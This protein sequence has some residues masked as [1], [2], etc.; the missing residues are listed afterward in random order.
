MAQRAACRWYHE[1]GAEAS[2]AVLKSVPE[3]PLALVGQEMV[4]A[5]QALALRTPE[6]SME[7]KQK[8]SAKKPSSAPTESRSQ[9]QRSEEAIARGSQRTPASHGGEDRS[10][11][12]R[13][14]QEVEK[15]DMLAPPA[16]PPV[17]LGPQSFVT[18]E[19]RVQ[20][21]LLLFSPEQS[22]RL[23]EIHQPPFATPSSAWP[24]SRGSRKIRASRFG[25]QDSSNH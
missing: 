18:P 7:G 25:W 22:A 1:G 4:P 23:Q 8:G 16:G 13:D 10:L 14:V 17:S 21:M 5:S 9:V 11:K 20:S 24:W 12:G 2:R 3:Q 19:G 15:K 6:G